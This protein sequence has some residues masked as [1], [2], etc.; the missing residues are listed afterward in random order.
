MP[1]AKNKKLSSK[2]LIIIIALF[3]A[4]VVIILLPKYL[5]MRKDSKIPGP[6]ADTVIFKQVAKEN[7]LEELKAGNIDYY[8]ASLNPE[9]AATAK[10][11][12]DIKLYSAYSEFVSIAL[13]PAPGKGNKLNPF[14]IK[15]VRQALNYI[16]DKE[17]IADE[18]Y[19]G[20]A[21]PVAANI[22]KEH[23]SYKNIKSVIDKYNFRVDKAKAEELIAAGMKEAGAVKIDGK[24]NFKNKPIE[25]N[26]YIDN[27]S[28]DSK[29][30][31]EIVSAN[32]EEVGFVINKNYYERSDEDFKI[33]TYTTDPNELKWNFDITGWIYYG[34]NKYNNF[35][36]PGLHEEKNGWKYE[37]KDIEKAEEE[38][39]TCTSQKKWEEL[40]RTLTDLYLD[41]SVG[42]WLVAKENLFPA[43]KNIKGL[44]NDKYIGLR[45]LEN[46]RQAKNKDT[47][48][49]I[50]GSEYLYEAGESWNPVVIESIGMMDIVNS[51]HDPIK[52]T[53]DKL[54]TKPLRWEYT[55]D[56]SD[57]INIPTDAFTWDIAN[58]KWINVAKDLKA[59]TKV[60]FD[61]SNYLGSS[62][63]SG[64]EINWGDILYFI[65]ATWD[66]AF[67]ET[68]QK[69]SG[70]YWQNN[71]NGL[72]GLKISE[73]EL[74]A[75]LDRTD[76]DENNLLKFSSIF[77]RSAPLEIYAGADKLI[78]GNNGF[79]YG[80]VGN[81]NLKKLNL[82]NKDHIAKIFE[83][84]GN[85]DYA[86]IE[87]FI[88]V[89]EIKYFSEKEFTNRKKALADWYNL[90][91]HLIISD[92]PFYM[93]KYDFET[94]NIIL[95]AFRDESYPFKK[96]VWHIK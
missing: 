14:S 53:N 26:T 31:F 12:K 7:A 95:K 36:F 66:R 93:D 69:I 11:D 57:N 94:G 64:E 71:F 74:I 25:L 70:D 86:E 72:Q 20:L 13:N 4:F 45:S 32:L 19:G 38:I 58:N 60:T 41:D 44:A 3:I 43:R 33:P 27:E 91:G 81:P 59:K 9:Q 83:K 89:N 34:V 50:I 85:I 75:Y 18:I 10:N 6:V 82:T 40:N 78:F 35:G 47:G 29:A 16:I 15:K 39:Q 48:A 30:I 63:H 5:E 46:I 2:I 77:Q 67:D 17:K 88:S 80:E 22:V 37:N 42:I 52:W 51:I 56:S 54:E 76:F 1:F 92:G 73:N 90:H 8:L 96:G 61:L 55:I 65:A 21:T 68:K 24:W 87:S 23:P 79:E 62:W 28:E 49:L 84:L